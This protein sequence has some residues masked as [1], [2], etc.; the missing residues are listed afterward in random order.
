MSKRTRLDKAEK[1]AGVTDKVMKVF[2]MDPNDDDLYHLSPARKDETPLTRAEAE[3]EADQLPGDAMILWVD[4][5][6]AWRGDDPQT[7]QT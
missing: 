6:R 4:Y 5:K 1:K 2:W 7:L 3:A